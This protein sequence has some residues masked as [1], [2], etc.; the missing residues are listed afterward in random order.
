MKKRTIALLCAAMMVVGIAA[1][2]T[3]A[4]LVAAPDTVTNTF[5]TSDITIKLDETTENYQMV[6]G[7]TIDKDP[8]VTVTSDSEDCYLFVK[9]EESEGF[10]T[11]VAYAIA[12]GWTPLEDVEG[13]YYR[14]IDDE[15]EKNIPYA[16]LGAGTYTD[17]NE[18]SYTWDENE[19]LTKP[20][21]TKDMMAALK[22]EGR[23][24][25]LTFTA[26]ASQYMKN[27]TTWFTPAEAWANANP[28]T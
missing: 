21:V 28:T 20:E 26:Y 4:W 22:T 14:V 13:V 17:S 23:L 1:G 27:N 9:V 19:V 10:D 11:Y 7:H 6:P 8:T 12:S 15:S 16:V 3:L 25:T 24:P 5:T 18:V 2:G